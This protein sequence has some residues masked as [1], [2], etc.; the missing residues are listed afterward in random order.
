[1]RKLNRTYKNWLD[2]NICPAPTL[3]QAPNDNNNCSFSWDE[4]PEGELIKIQNKQKRIFENEVLKL[5]H[6]FQAIFIKTYEASKEKKYFLRNQIRKWQEVLFDLRPSRFQYTTAQESDLTFDSNHLYDIRNYIRAIYEEGKSLDYSFIHSPNCQFHYHEKIDAR[7]EA[8]V[9]FR[10]WKILRGKYQILIENAENKPK[11]NIKFQGSDENP[12]PLIFRDYYAF[13]MFEELML[14]MVNPKSKMADYAFIYHRM[15]NKKE[16][17]IHMH[18]KHKVFIDFLNENF[19]A[20]I[21]GEKFPVVNPKRKQA[22]FD[23]HL[24]KYKEAVG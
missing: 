13:K 11:V 7:I 9:Y 21:N 8:E 1:M 5:L 12:Y 3:I 17:L 23:F 6:K 19:N 22:A 2:G 10:F 18:V 4:F 14:T 16:P 24:K 15:K 20:G